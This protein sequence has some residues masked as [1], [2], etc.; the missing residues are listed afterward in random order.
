M[1]LE[2]APA[3]PQLGTRPYITDGGIETDLIF[4]RGFAL[5]EFAA[6]VLLDDARGRDELRAYYREYLA[7]AREFD[8][9]VLLDTPTWRASRDWGER[10]GYA[11]ARLAEI[12][13]G[14]VRL[15]DQ[16]RPEAPAVVVSGCVGPRADAYVP[17]QRMTA[18]EAE[19]YHAAQVQALADAGADL[20][21]A[22]TLAYAEEAVGIVRAAVRAEIPVAISF[23][24]ETD[25]ELPDR[26]SLPDAIARVDAETDSA[27]AYFMINCAHPTHFAGVLTSGD[28]RM[29]RIRGLKA[30][31]SARSHEELDASDE[32]DEGDPL[33]LAARYGELLDRLP[34]LTVLGGC[35][36][37]DRRHHAAICAMRARRRG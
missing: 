6:F 16:L 22:L 19:A 12:N 8:V 20:I 31:A 35:C 32:L 7:L 17:E 5:P 13:R 36:G 14:A 28:P 29:A 34:G 2:T 27:A 30:N 1:A 24:V 11:P 23:T 10:L 21:T 3:R 15:L 26:R 18:A 9:G 4:H 33:D 37:T 25:G